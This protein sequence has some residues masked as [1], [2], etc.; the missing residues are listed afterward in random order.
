[1][2]RF[3]SGWVI[4]LLVLNLGLALFLF[5]WAQIVRIPTEPD[6]TTGHVWAH[7][8]L[9][10]GVRNL[11]IW[12]VVFSAGVLLV[13]LI[14]FALYPGF[15]G[16]PGALGWTSAE[17]LQRDT[18]A[19]NAKIE[20]RMQPLR[21]LNLNELA[22]NSDATAIGHRLYLDN[23]A[24][25]HGA[26]ARGNQAL[27]APN[28]TDAEWLYGGDEQT[29]M[30]S[31]LDGRNGVMPPWGPALGHE[32]V[33]EATAYVLSLSG[34]NAPKD[35]IAPG[36][37]RYEAVCV[38]C[39]GTDGRGNPAIGVPNLTDRTWIYGGEFARVAESIR[40]GRN[41]VMPGWR[42]RLSEDQVRMIAAWVV[43]QGRRAPS[44]T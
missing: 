32:G 44:E 19:N 21:A 42:S 28:L 40:E 5:V 4:F 35:W 22:A 30:A 1:M 23:C 9:R 34:I 33:N 16:L 17:E 15:G 8:V 43:A 18:A 13:G 39:H 37:A 31:I 2:S 14:Y 36:K 6:G 41:G 24:A 11:P 10:E 38:A 25:C 26:E 29:F 20:A 7:G 12:W 27:G 3:W